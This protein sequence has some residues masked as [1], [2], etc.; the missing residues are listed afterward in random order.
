MITCFV[1][2][3]IVKDS[4]EYEWIGYDGDKIHKK[5]KPNMNKAYDRINR[6]NDSGFAKYMKGERELLDT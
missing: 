5:C 6:M 4:D 2:G 3:K 1:C